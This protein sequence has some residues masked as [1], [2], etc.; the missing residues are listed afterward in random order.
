M[1]ELEKRIDVVACA[2]DDRLWKMA[3][4]ASE[5]KAERV[6]GWAA[7]IAGHRKV[8]R[9]TRTVRDWAR[10]VEATAEIRRDRDCLP[11]S[12][13]AAVARY[14]PRVD[15]DDLADMID[16]AADGTVDELEALL[17]EQFGRPNEPD[18]SGW[19]QKQYVDIQAHIDAAPVAA[20]P[21]L[22]VAVASLKAAQVA[23]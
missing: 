7:L 12:G 4:L 23:K 6:E 10:T 2:L 15:A 5:L 19:C 8:R 22:D 17:R 20:R 13:W 3:E 9:S 1:K 18:F 14:W 11:F 16:A 21:H